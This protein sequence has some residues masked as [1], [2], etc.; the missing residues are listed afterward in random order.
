MATYRFTVEEVGTGTVEVDANSEDEAWELA[1][2]A[3]ADGKYKPK[4]IDGYK[5]LDC[6]VVD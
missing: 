2:D 5:I 3:L 6:E 1:D 4:E